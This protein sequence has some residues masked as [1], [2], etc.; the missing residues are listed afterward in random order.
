MI[1]S[2]ET[3]DEE[4]DLYMESIAVVTESEFDNPS[5]RGTLLREDGFQGTFLGNCNKPY[6]C[7]VYDLSSDNV[8]VDSKL[9]IVN[10]TEGEESVFEMRDQKRR[11]FG[12]RNDQWGDVDESAGYCNVE[13]E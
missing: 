3:G 1:L 4:D 5:Y 11:K 10:E 9:K 2:K 7:V 6:R 13:R 8:A 12:S